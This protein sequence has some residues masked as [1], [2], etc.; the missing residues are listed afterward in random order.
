MVDLMKALLLSLKG[1]R[2]YVLFQI[3]KFRLSKDFFLLS[4]ERLFQGF[5]YFP[6][7]SKK[8]IKFK[9]LLLSLFVVCFFI[10]VF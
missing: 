1:I 8:K 7:F 3:R 2:F 4:F 5:E 9:V 6:F 10:F